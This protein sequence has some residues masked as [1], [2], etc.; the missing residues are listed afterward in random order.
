MLLRADVAEAL[1]AEWLPSYRERCLSRF[2]LYLKHPA[3]HQQYR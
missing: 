1:I 3:S 2:R